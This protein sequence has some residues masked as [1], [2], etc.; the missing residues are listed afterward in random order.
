MIYRDDIK[1]CEG[2]VLTLKHYKDEVKEISVGQECGIS[3]ENFNDIKEND[4][5]E[6]YTMIE[7]KR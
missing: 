5:I 1:I 2:N 3:I 4:I 6:S 7:I